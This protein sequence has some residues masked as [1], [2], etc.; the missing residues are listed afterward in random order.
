MIEQY[1]NRLIDELPEHIIEK[2]KKQK[3]M[4]II[5]DGGFFNGSY[6]IGALYFLKELENRKYIKI[7]KLSGCSI[8]S[9]SA[10]LYL[11]DELDMSQEMYNIIVKSF[12]ETHNLNSM[13]TILERIREKLPEDFYKKIENKLFVSYYNIETRKKIVKSKF[14]NNNQ[15]ID[16]IKRSCFVPFMINGDLTYKNKYIDGLFPHIFPLKKGLIDNTKTLYLDLL[17][18]DKLKHLLS[19]K[20][21][22]SNYHRI[23]SGVLDIHLFFIKENKTQMC[24]YVE[25]WDLIDTFK[26]RIK[27]AIIETIIIWFIYA[28]YLI[29]KYIDPEL[30]KNNILFKI[31]NKIIQDI[32]FIIVENYCF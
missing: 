28:I 21:E 17:C 15:L 5:L 24:S 18:F 12:K 11:M 23:L 30:Y 7:N 4:N 14:K 20:N 3:K 29:K 27:K 16:F 13:I 25:D 32:Y 9:V 6:L 31:L 22:S 8:G 2:L 10:L 1:V 19:V 26:Q